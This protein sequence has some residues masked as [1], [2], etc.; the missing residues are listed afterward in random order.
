MQ[1]FD[2]SDVY[3]AFGSGSLGYDC[4]TCGARCCRGFGYGSRGP[5]L[6]IQLRRRPHLSLFVASDDGE[7]PLAHEV[8]N[9]PPAC[10]FLTSSG[11]CEIHQ[12]DGYAAKPETC[13]LSPSIGLP[14]SG[15]T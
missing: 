10:F 11:A 3:F 9:L 13:R 15:G 12:Q 7:G 6:L 14:A 8:Q 1:R 5:E 2:A 4:Q